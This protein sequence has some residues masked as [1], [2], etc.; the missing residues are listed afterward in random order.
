MSQ[1]TP[2]QARVVDP[3]LTAVARGYEANLLGAADALFPTVNV[4]TRGGKI[5]VFGREAFQIVNSKRAPGSST[6]RL[7]ISYG[8]DNYYLDDHG[9]EAMVPIEIEQEASQIPIDMG[10]ESIQVVQQQMAL[11]REYIAAMLATTAANYP[12]SNKSTLS[13]ADQ[14]THAD[15]NP[16][17]AFEAAKEAVR[18]KTG[19]RPNT[20]VLGPTVLNA[21]RSHPVVMGKIST[22]TDRVPATIAQLQAMF[23]ID[24]IIEGQAIYDNS[25]SSTADFNDVWGKDA[26]LAYVNTQP[27]PNKGSQSYGYTYQLSGYPNVEM[28]YED[29]N[30]KSAIYPINDA[31]KAILV[32][33]TSGFLF[34]AAAA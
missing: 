12:A 18:K 3:I 6:K 26:V 34:K 2:S 22:S 20:A 5:I 8:S 14:W 13:G 17:A 23:E 24:K 32:G 19:R 29:R 21:L 4:A 25:G 7:Q 10:A 9:L 15:S 31:R 33:N 30:R 28:A 1:M 16:F 11:E 27:L